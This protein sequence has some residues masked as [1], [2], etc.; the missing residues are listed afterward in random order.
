MAAILA[1]GERVYLFAS[2]I[3][4]HRAI[5]LASSCLGV[6]LSHMFLIFAATLCKS[7]PHV[8]HSNLYSS[9]NSA[10]V[11]EIITLTLLA[12]T[13]GNIARLSHLVVGDR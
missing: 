2:A 8:L 12:R 5:I 11:Q 10:A 1:R 13:I 9:I 6:L 4:I 3:A 7:K